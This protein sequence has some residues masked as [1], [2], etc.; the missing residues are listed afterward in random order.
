[1]LRS[2]E[3]GAIIAACGWQNWPGDIAQMGVYVPE[4]ARGDGIAHVVAADATCRAIHAGRL[5]LWRSH[6]D[7]HRSIDLAKFL[8]YREIGS[9]LTI[10]L[11][12]SN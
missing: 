11:A 1:M 6:V 2:P 7:N 10:R 5:P 12:E 8:G 9:Q 3:D 4:R